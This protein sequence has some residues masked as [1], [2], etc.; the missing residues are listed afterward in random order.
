M[1]PLDQFRNALQLVYILA[2]TSIAVVNVN[3][4]TALLLGNH[5]AFK[6]DRIEAE[7]PIPVITSFHE[8]CH[9]TFHIRVSDPTPPPYLPTTSL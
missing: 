7:Y 4:I 9:E 2:H 1:E 5:P 3:R 8:I 6:S